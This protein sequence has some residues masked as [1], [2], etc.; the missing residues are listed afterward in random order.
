M[1]SRFSALSAAACAIF[2]AACNFR[3]GDPGPV[4]TPP[5][6]TPIGE[7]I[8]LVPTT[9][10]LRIFDLGPGEAYE[11]IAE[12]PW[13]DLQAGDLVRIHYRPEPY[14]GIIGMDGIGTEENPIRIYGIPGP[15]GEL[16]V[17]S[18][19][20]AVAGDNLDGGF[21]DQ[22]TTG[23]GVI[24]ILG[25]WYEPDPADPPPPTRPE[26]LEFANLGITGAYRDYRYTD[27]TGTHAWADG[28]A[29]FWIRAGHVSILG[30]EI[31]GNGNGVFTQAN[32]AIMQNISED[33][34]VEGCRIYHNGTVG[35]D[36]Y[37]NLYIQGAGMTIQ[38]CYIGDLRDGAEGSS[39]KDRSSGTVIRYNH[40]EA[41]ARL[42]D[43]VEPEDTYELLSAQPD[44][45]VTYVYGNILVNDAS[46]PNGGCGTLFHYG[47]DN[48]DLYARN[49]TLFFYDNTVVNL[50]RQSVNWRT[51]LFEAESENADIRCFNNIFAHFGDADNQILAELGDVRAEGG[52]WIS[53]GW[54]PHRP[55]GAGP[56]GTVTQVVAFIEGTDPGIV[57][58][59]GRDFRLE[60]DSPAR[61]AA[62]P[63]PAEITDVH[64]VLYQYA[65]GAIFTPRS[66]FNDLG[67]L[68]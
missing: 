43:L 59:A 29:A 60:S 25:P 47:A 52:N 55:D 26:Y 27:E 10:V 42:L 44:F 22:W 49:G 68:E 38:F 51:N 15:H 11:E 34:L 18:G 37:H 20:G 39:L 8:Y 40:I 30:C 5:P 36:R 35:T 6:F 46:S 50:S 65:E 4:V 63:L 3:M 13:L 62:V 64:P 17:I 12:L 28:S 31:S 14:V 66:S 32:S 1:K 9:G 53:A 41:S 57:D 21:F 67:A 2:L 33:T 56:Y 24:L 23:L 58:P 16:P 54:M 61:N 45:G 19:A 7:T 48:V